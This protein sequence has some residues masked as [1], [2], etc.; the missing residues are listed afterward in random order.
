MANIRAKQYALPQNSFWIWGFHC[1]SLRCWN[2]KGSPG[3]NL[4]TELLS[5]YG[6]IF[7]LNRLSL[8]RRW[9]WADFNAV[10]EKWAKAHW[11][12]TTT[13][14]PAMKHYVK[15]VITVVRSDDCT[16]FQVAGK[17]GDVR[18]LRL[19]AQLGKE[20][21]GNIDVL[22]SRARITGAVKEEAVSCSWVQLSS[23]SRVEKTEGVSTVY[24]V[25]FYI[26]FQ[27]WCLSPNSSHWKVARK[28]KSRRYSYQF[29]YRICM[30]PFCWASIRQGQRNNWVTRL[31]GPLLG[32]IHLVWVVRPLYLQLTTFL[33][34][35][36]LAFK[37]I[38]LFDFD[39]S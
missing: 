25:A 32:Y 26:L 10:Q 14:L 30:Y 16:V 24:F 1:N 7:S 5:L 28:L 22:S 33:T 20:A 2:G 38:K 19:E 29:Y 34:F 11:A 35:A 21:T 17:P 12:I 3:Q 27:V 8:K 31:L 15:P 18:Q 13:R 4:Q 36:L 6:K 23:R 9:F 39:I 37:E